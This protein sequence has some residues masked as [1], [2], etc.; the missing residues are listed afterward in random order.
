LS[1]LCLR[2]RN[3][4]IKARYILWASSAYQDFGVE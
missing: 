3:R 4:I 2:I 1:F